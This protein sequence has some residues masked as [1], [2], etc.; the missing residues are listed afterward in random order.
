M[1]V[2]VSATGRYIVQL[3]RGSDAGEFI[4]ARGIDPAS[5][6][7]YHNVFSG[8]SAVLDAA[9]VRS[10]VDNPSVV[11]VEPD[12][13]VSLQTDQNTGPVSTNIPNSGTLPWGLDQ[14]DQRGGAANG[15][16]SYSAD[17]TGVRVY[18]VDTGIRAGA[19]QF[20][21]RLASGYA[22]V[23]ADDGGMSDCNGHGSHVAGTVAGTTVGVAPG[24]TITPVR[25]LACDG[26]GSFAT[27][28]AGINWM[29]ADHASGVPAVAN[30]SL[31]GDYSAAVNAAIADAKIGRAHV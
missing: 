14:I 6:V 4:T 19:T 1:E 5:T 29:I 23:G 2:P 13:L 11:S 15:V 31:G 20:G 27:V 12:Q 24:A 3:R 9:E 21:N 22:V 25:V 28:I 17:G 10:L 30:L 7:L 16:Y 18:V 26:T 8:F